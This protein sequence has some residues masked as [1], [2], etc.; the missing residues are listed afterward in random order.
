MCFFPWAINWDPVDP[1]AVEPSL[2]PSMFQDLAEPEPL[3]LE[4]AFAS[5]WHSRALR[6]LKFSVRVSSWTSGY[7]NLLQ[8]KSRGTI[9]STK[10]SVR[11]YSSET[12]SGLFLS[13]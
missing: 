3:D 8:E 11:I 5:I 4:V 2:C 9:A 13:V 12:A 10:T 7:G 6:E 1:V